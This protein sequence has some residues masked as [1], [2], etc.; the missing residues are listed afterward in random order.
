MLHI[1]ALHLQGGCR[2]AMFTSTWNTACVCACSY[3]SYQFVPKSKQNLTNLSKTYFWG[4]PLDRQTDTSLECPYLD[5]QIDSLSDRQI[6]V[7]VWRPSVVK[8][9]GWSVLR[10]LWCVWR[11]GSQAHKGFCPSGTAWPSSTTSL[12]PDWIPNPSWG[13][14][15]TGLKKTWGR[16]KG[17]EIKEQVVFPQSKEQMEQMYSLA[18]WS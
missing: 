3:L 11:Q 8:N 4:C 14:Y 10:F 16:S 6:E 1:T 18:V 17:N 2:I 7:C 13:R 12:W 15:K 5:R 9:R